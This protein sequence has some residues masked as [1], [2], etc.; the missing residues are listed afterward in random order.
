MDPQR[1]ILEQVPAALQ[2][3]LEML[4]GSEVSAHIEPGA[5]T[6]TSWRETRISGGETYRL[7]IGADRETWTGIASTILGAAGV[8]SADEQE[9]RSTWI[10]VVDQ[11]ASSAVRS[12]G[13]KLGTTLESQAG[14]DVSAPDGYR[15]RIALFIDGTKWAV[16]V[17]VR[18]DQAL[19]VRQDNSRPSVDNQL[20]KMA[21]SRTM[22]ALL[23]VQLPVSISFGQAKMPL[24]DV[25]KLSTGTVV[26]LNRL[27]EDPVDIIVNDS[28]IARGE[29][30]VVDGNYAVRIQSIIGRQDRIGIGSEGLEAGGR[31][32]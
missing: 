25:L 20:A 15:Q 10:E 24:K 32:R 14:T 30:V 6:A 18:R 9:L 22:N 1:T 7:A 13:S 11:T 17:V 21:G 26:E 19:E 3:T 16:E 28:V 27:P 4:T 2:A 5:G 12:S 29:V 23:D 31:N 8:S